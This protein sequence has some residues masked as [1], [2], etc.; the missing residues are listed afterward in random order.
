ML[1]WKYK[2]CFETLCFFSVKGLKKN[3][4]SGQITCL[5]RPKNPQNGSVLGKGNGNPLIS[6]GNRMVDEIL[7]SRE[8]TYPPDKAYL[9]MIFL[10]PRWDMLIPWRVYYSILAVPRKTKPPEKRRCSTCVEVRFFGGIWGDSRGWCP[11][12]RKK[13]GWHM[14]V[15]HLHV[16]VRHKLEMFDV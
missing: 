16:D 8:L 4:V 5:A 14:E 13:P 12:V 7:P 15:H 10:F 1:F 3:K 6:G 9:K 11:V 2:Y